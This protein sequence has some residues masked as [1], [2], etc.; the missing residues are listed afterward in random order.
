MSIWLLKYLKLALY[1]KIV[2]LF[3]LPNA[4]TCKCGFC[5]QSFVGYCVFV[6]LF[7]LHV[8][9]SISWLVF[10]EDWRIENVQWLVVMLNVAVHGAEITLGACRIEIDSIF[11]RIFS[12]ILFTFEDCRAGTCEPAKLLSKM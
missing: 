11:V 10:E 2:A 1:S 5:F 7:E 3:S 9:L 12:T 4:M 6:C 8:Y